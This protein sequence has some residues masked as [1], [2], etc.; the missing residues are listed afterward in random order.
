MDA[1]AFKVGSGT[2]VSC[3]RPQMN[4]KVITPQL[5]IF[6]LLPTL[7]APQIVFYLS[8]VTLLVLGYLSFRKSPLDAIPTVGHSSFITSY[9]TALR[10][11]RHGDEILQEGYNKYAG[12]PFKVATMSRWVV[13]LS[14]KKLLDDMKTTPDEVISLR[15]AVVETMHIEYTLGRKAD[16][17]SYHNMTIR[18]PLTRQMM[19]KFDEIRDEI[20]QSFAEY[21]PLT[22]DWVT[23]PAFATV[24]HIVCRINTRYFIGLPLCRNA[25]YRLL[26]EGFT[27]DVAIS[28]RIINSVPSFMRPFVGKYLTTAQKTLRRAMEYLGPLIRERLRR[29]E[30]HGLHWPDRPNDLVSWLLDTCTEAKHRTVDDL[31][32]RIL[33]INFASLHT[34]SMA[35]TQALFD[36]AIHP[37]YIMELRQEVEMAISELGWTKAA[38]QRMHKLDSFLKESQRL[39][40]MGTMLMTRKVIQEWRLSDG[41][42]IPAGAFIA[43]AS[44]A[45]NNDKK[46]FL[47]P[48][49][50]SGFRFVTGTD[51]SD[52]K[53]RGIASLDPTYIVFGYDRHAW[54]APSSSVLFQF[55]HSLHESFHSPGRFFV[56]NEIK[57]IL[58]H[59]LLN[60]DVQL[61][62]GSMERP[63]NLVMET[64]ITPNAIAKMMF[65]K[66][67]ANNQSCQS[68]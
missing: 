53:S 20:V 64:T 63:R 49:V 17:D 55:V 25:G 48:H 47:D 54:Y 56:I 15:R 32:M 22:E 41:T 37:E 43:V 18:S 44:G 9:L 34:T 1:S 16:E 23:V 28:T 21:I 5:F 65:R 35:T 2:S 59:V 24:I 30:L 45:M 12:R 40:N 31:V 14:G 19:N 68:I 3:L 6:A 58:A 60:Y 61:E 7:S 38:V 11:T 4:L 13:I 8:T 67:S 10:W 27:Y 26:I 62:N 46:T 51:Q 50:F 57:T 29:E 42:I 66:R 36:L 39:N 33:N 52:Q